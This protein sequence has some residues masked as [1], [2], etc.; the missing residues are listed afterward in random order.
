MIALNKGIDMRTTTNSNNQK[1]QADLSSISDNHELSLTT[2]TS[3]WNDQVYRELDDQ[4]LSV[5]DPLMQLQS[6][7][8]TLSDLQF[9]YSFLMREIQYLIKA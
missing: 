1:N 6:N 8:E 4:P 5:Q 2:L 9:R 7:L 3:V